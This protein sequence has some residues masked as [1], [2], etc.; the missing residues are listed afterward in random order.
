MPKKK[1][2]K[3]AGSR[4]PALF[5]FEIRDNYG[6]PINLEHS[7]SQLEVRQKVL[8]NPLDDQVKK[9][10]SSDWEIDERKARELL[11]A[12]SELFRDYTFQLYR[13]EEWPEVVERVEKIRIMVVTSSYKRE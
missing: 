10:M 6:K 7:L 1:F 5:H 4:M 12:F 9:L 13:I 3:R 2:F 11:L 8:P